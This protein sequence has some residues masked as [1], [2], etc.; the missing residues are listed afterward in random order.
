MKSRQR[1]K[2]GRLLFVRNA[3]NMIRGESGKGKDTQATAAN[4][5]R[6]RRASAGER[7]YWGARFVVDMCISVM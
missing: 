1:K 7:D 5:R 4:G 3:C 2:D 6:R